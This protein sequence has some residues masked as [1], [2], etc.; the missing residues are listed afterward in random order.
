MQLLSF[1]H[2][3]VH[4]P[5]LKRHSTC[6]CISQ[7]S[8]VSKQYVYPLLLY[9]RYWRL[10]TISQPPN[11]KPPPLTRPQREALFDKCCADL[12]HEADNGAPYPRGWFSPLDVPL[13]RQDVIDWLLWALFSCER[14]EAKMEEWKEELEAY[15][16][17]IEVMLGENLNEGRGEGIKTMRLTLDPVKVVHRPLVWYSVS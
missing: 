15:V 13:C 17:M 1:R 8:G 3:L 2:G 4:L 7:G 11:Y 6:W 16:K 5:L 14:Q 12:K 10:K 9:C